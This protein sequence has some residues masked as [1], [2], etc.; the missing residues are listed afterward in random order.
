[1]SCHQTSA[2]IRRTQIIVATKDK[3]W[4]LPMEERGMKIKEWTIASL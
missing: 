1:M 3:I 4:E 2:A